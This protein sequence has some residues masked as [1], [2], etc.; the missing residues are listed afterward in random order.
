M[1]LSDLV[2]AATAGFF[3]RAIALATAAA[4]LAADMVPAGALGLGVVAAA[5]AVGTLRFAL[6]AGKASMLGMIHAQLASAASNVGIVLIAA[7]VAFTLAP[8]A[9]GAVL[10]PSM[11][12]SAVAAVI[13]GHII[14]GSRVPGYGA[15]LPL[16]AVLAAAGAGIRAEDHVDPLLGYTAVAGAACIVVAAAVGVSGELRGIYRVNIFHYVLAWA[17]WL[18]ANVL[19]DT[20]GV[21]GGPRPGLL[22]HL[23]PE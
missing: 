22:L 14:L 16:V 8:R 21:G 18:W 5:A 3:A 12:A 10:P 1:A 2:L 20:R 23:A 19:L 17:L 15:V 9:L 7:D 6:G 13:A 4:P 11:W